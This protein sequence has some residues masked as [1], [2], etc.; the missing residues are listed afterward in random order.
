[1]DVEV[2]IIREIIEIQDMLKSAKNN[3]HPKHLIK[4]YE[5]MIEEKQD[6]LKMLEFVKDFE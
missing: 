6:E 3:Q 2:Q 1:M 5:K 4:M